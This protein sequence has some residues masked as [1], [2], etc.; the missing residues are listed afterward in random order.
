MHDHSHL[1]HCF[2][3]V[4][5]LCQELDKANNAITQE[6]LKK[7]G[8]DEEDEGSEEPKETAAQRALKAN[9]QLRRPQSFNKQAPAGPAAPARP[10]AGPAS[11]S[12][13]PKPKV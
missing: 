12:S 2:R 5:G 6:N 8:G 10:K 13:R 9:P 7:K 3:A 4:H 11:F 1:I